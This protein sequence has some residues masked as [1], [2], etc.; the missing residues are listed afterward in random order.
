MDQGR[1]DPPLELRPQ[2][3][4]V[5]EGHAPGPALVHAI[6][7][8]PEGP[9]G[10]PGVA[11][12]VGDEEENGVLGAGAILDGGIMTDRIRSEK[13]SLIMFCLILQL[14]CKHGRK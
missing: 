8:A 2:A 6:L 12:V 7:L 11:A 4:I 1:R 3:G 5:E 13:S 9:V 10:S 14:S